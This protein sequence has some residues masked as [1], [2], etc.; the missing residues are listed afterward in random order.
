MYLG[1]NCWMMRTVA[2]LLES[3]CLIYMFPPAMSE[4]SSFSTL[5]QQLLVSVFLP[6]A[7]RL[8]IKQK[9][10]GGLIGISLTTNNTE[11]LCQW[12]LTICEYF[13]VE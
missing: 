9:V 13:L 5:S 4:Y 2:K 10:S 7:V 11:N 1:Q 8:G 12:S 6:T 3:Y